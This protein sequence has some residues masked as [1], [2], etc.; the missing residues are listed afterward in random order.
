ML[1]RSLHKRKQGHLSPFLIPASNV[2]NCLKIDARRWGNKL[3]TALG[4]SQIIRNLKSNLS[5]AFSLSTKVIVL[6]E[7]YY[8]ILVNNK[9]P[10]QKLRLIKQGMPLI[11][12]TKEKKTIQKSKLNLIFIG[13]INQEKGLHLLIDALLK[14]KNRG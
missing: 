2:L 9:V 13:R 4:T 12:S 6:T 1:F 3:G 11:Q 8:S 7:W 5:E 14:I 10:K